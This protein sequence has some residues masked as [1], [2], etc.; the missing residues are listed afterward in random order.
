MGRLPEAEKD[1]DQAVSLYKQ[2]A[3]DLPSRL[4]YR[5]NLAKSH[6]NRGILLSKTGRLEEAKKAYDQALSIRKQLAADFPSQPEFRENL[7]TSYNSRGILLCNMDRLLDAEKDYDQAVSIQ[8][9]LAADFPNQPDLRN[10]LAGSCVNVAILNEKLGNWAAAKQLLMDG[11]P[12]HLAALKANPRNPTYRRYYR[13]YLAVLTAAHVGL[14]EQ[15]E[16]LRTAE[17]CR[18]LGWDAPEDTYSA[19]CGLSRCIPAV[20]KHP[21]LDAK[22]REEAVQLYSD[23]AMKALSEAVSKGYKNVRLLKTDDD[24]DPLRKREDFQKLVAKLEGK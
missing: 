2:L 11:L 6:L 14:L 21:K 22:Q 5:Q 19:A 17:T 16:A 24:L 15:R 13:N 1:Y 7:A 10:D 18:N 23:A 8:K 9:Q 20:A 3:T 12:H 4:E